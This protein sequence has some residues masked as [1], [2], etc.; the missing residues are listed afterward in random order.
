M[1]SAPPLLFPSPLWGGIKGGGRSE[2]KH[3]FAPCVLT[4][5]NPTPPPPHKGERK[6]FLPAPQRREKVRHQRRKAALLDERG[7]G[8]RVGG[9]FAVL[10]A[11]G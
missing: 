5:P 10:V 6:Y 3:L 4:L 2:F 11:L 9:E 8:L 7:D 1:A